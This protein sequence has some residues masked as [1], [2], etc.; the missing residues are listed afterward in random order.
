MV[1]FAGLKSGFQNCYVALAWLALVWAV[2]NSV[3][4][5]LVLGGERTFRVESAAFILVGVL[6]PRIFWRPSVGQLE[7]V[8][9]ATDNSLLML[10]ALS[11]WLLTLGPFLTLPFLSD[12]YVFLASYKRLS[13]VLSVGHFFRPAFGL[14]FLLMAQVGNGSP[15]PFHVLAL[16]IHGVS[17]SC[18]YVLSRRLFR[19]TD[20]ATFC[21]AIFLRSEERRV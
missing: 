14:V 20:A 18:D 1:T 17:A 2:G 5:Y 6:L 3:Y 21:F 10:L 4:V 11:L 9:T 12:D 19:R 8:L 13:D 7:P 16:I 15:V